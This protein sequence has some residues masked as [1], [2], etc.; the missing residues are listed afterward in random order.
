MTQMM[1]ACL[2]SMLNQNQPQISSATIGNI[3]IM[4]QTGNLITPMAINPSNNQVSNKKNLLK[5]NQLIN[6]GPNKLNNKRV[7]KINSKKRRNNN[8]N[9]SGNLNVN[10]PNSSSNFSA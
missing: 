3:P 9:S 1:A 2:E 6:I 5:F 4:N 7:K 8:V 10:N